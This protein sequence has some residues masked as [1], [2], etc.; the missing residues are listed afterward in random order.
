MIYDSFVTY[1]IASL[2]HI[3]YEYNKNGLC[4]SLITGD[5]LITCYY[6]VIKKKKKKKKKLKTRFVSYGNFVSY[7]KLV[8]FS[9][10][11]KYHVG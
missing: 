6:F 1:G 8:F 5:N 4:L 9:F 3:T 10:V 11:N 2:M 7:G